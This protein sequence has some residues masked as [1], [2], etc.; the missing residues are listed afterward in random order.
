MNLRFVYHRHSHGDRYQEQCIV[1]SDRPMPFP[2]KSP[3]LNPIKV[4]WNA[5][6]RFIQRRPVQP[7]NLAE[8]TQ[9]LNEE[10]QRFPQ[11]K[12]RRLVASMR[13]RCQAC[14]A[15]RGRHARN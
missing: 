3:D 4:M 9:A 10:W 6:D 1:K 11:Y 14:R 5:L 2:S 12:L 8:L 15:A 7:R 13:R